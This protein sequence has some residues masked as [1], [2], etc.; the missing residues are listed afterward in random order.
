[1]SVKALLQAAQFV[2]DAEGRKK[3][4]MLDV[5][6][7][8]ELRELLAQTHVVTEQRALRMQ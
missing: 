5:A 6:V 8:D 7:W 1:M 3:A 2:V 4:V